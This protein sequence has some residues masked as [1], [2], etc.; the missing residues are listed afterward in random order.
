[1]DFSVWHSEFL[2]FQSLSSLTKHFETSIICIKD[3]VVYIAQTTSLQ[4]LR[5]FDDTGEAKKSRSLK[6][7]SVNGHHQIQGIKT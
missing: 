6:E 4:R 3:S 7:L 5:T 1:M 2:N